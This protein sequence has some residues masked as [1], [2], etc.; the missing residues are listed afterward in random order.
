MCNFYVFLFMCFA[1]LISS[2]GGPS[3]IPVIQ[4]MKYHFLISKVGRVIK[5]LNLVNTIFVT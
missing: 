1:F 4:L 2:K 3:V 5:V